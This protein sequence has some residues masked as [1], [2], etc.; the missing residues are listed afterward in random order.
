MTAGKPR[1]RITAPATVTRDLRR[2]LNG[3]ASAL[4][5]KV[6]ARALSGD[7]VAQLACAELLSLAN[8]QQKKSP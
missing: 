1:G 8:S 7:S 5:Q 3:A 4:A 6:L 2:T